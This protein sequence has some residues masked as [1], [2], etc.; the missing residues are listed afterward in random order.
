MFSGKI[1]PT[2]CVLFVCESLTDK[3]ITT[4]TVTP[5]IP[6]FRG[7]Q[8]TLMNETCDTLLDTLTT[9]INI[10]SQL[11]EYI[12]SESCRQPTS[13]VFFLCQSPDE[14]DG[15]D[16]HHYAT[17]PGNHHQGPHYCHPRTAIS[18]KITPHQHIIIIF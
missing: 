11:F 10:I 1:A 4:M 9:L 15:Y 18:C 12:F 7:H 6:W 8:P 3:E 13:S 16:D 17:D 2:S 5:N 14:E